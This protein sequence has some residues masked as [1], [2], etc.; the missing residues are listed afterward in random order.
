MG[1]NDNKTEKYIKLF[2]ILISQNRTYH[3]HKETMAHAVLAIQL[4]IFTWIISP[5]NWP[6]VWINDIYISANCLSLIGFIILWIFT[7]IFIRWQLRNRR[8][9]AIIQ[10]AYINTI[11]TWINEIPSDEKL[12]P[13]YP[14]DNKKKRFIVFL[15]YIFPCPCAPLHYDSDKNSYPKCFIDEWETQEKV[16]TGAIR[17][18]WLLWFASFFMFVIVLI[19]IH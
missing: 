16:S 10:T 7:H 14:R 5:N 6:P 15:D 13:Y 8:S 17:S 2:E 19:R 11:K 4:A 1:E 3:N 9:S 12:Q 18:E